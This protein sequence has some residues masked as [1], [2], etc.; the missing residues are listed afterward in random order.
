MNHSEPLMLLPAKKLGL[1]FEYDSNDKFL[2]NLVF[3]FF[4]FTC[5]KGT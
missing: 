5:F 3:S 2:E 1:Q 4:F